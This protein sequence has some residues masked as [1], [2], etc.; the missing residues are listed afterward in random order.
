MIIEEKILK[1]GGTLISNKKPRPRKVKCHK[2]SDTGHSRAEQGVLFRFLCSIYCS[3]KYHNISHLIRRFRNKE[4][5]GR[6]ILSH[7]S[8]YPTQMQY[9][10]LVPISLLTRTFL[11]IPG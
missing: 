7:L 8:N 10:S 11:K 1:L 3:T 4:E 9:I 5:K 6:N 2:A